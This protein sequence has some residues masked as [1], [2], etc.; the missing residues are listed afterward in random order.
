MNYELFASGA[1]GLLVPRGEACF[2]RV[3]DVGNKKG[4]RKGLEDHPLLS[5]KES[6]P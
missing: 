2:F 6:I 1:F 4:I 5:R 3:E